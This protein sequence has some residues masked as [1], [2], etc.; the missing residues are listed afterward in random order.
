MY[1]L[2]AGGDIFYCFYFRTRVE[3][4]AS[5]VV[6][7]VKIERSDTVRYGAKGKITGEIV[8]DLFGL[9]AVSL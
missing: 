9:M 5:V 4:W 2:A 3:I 6:H 8:V 7:V 1:T